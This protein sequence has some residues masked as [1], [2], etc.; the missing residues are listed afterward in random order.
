MLRAYI[1]GAGHTMPIGDLLSTQLWA[2]AIERGDPAHWMGDAPRFEL[3]TWRARLAHLERIAA[4]AGEP[5]ALRAWRDEVRGI[6]DTCAADAA[7]H[8]EFQTR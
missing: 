8:P 5:P 7:A 2:E 6:V 4:L 1:A 3:E